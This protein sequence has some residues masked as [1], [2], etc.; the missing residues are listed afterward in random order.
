MQHLHEYEI[1]SDKSG[2]EFVRFVTPSGVTGF[3]ASC[4]PLAALDALV[5]KLERKI[6]RRACALNPSVEGFPA[7]APARP[8]TAAG[9]KATRR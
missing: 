5:R 2:R 7:L 4:I 8:E 9:V 6:A 1:V 3:V